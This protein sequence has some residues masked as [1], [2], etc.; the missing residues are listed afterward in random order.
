MLKSYRNKLCR[1]KQ[2]NT[3]RRSFQ[4]QSTIIFTL[5][6]LLINDLTVKDPNNNILVKFAD[7]M[8]V[9]APVKNN[10]DSAPAEINNIEKWT[11]TNRVSL[12]GKSTNPL[13]EPTVVGIER[14]T[15]LKLLG[16]TL[17]NDPSCWDLQVD[18]LIII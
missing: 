12:S 16:T 9:R 11:E 14:K 7:D 4:S 13:P 2:R 5:R 1:H 18:N 8:T 6:S 10:Y 17:Q 15:W 3:A